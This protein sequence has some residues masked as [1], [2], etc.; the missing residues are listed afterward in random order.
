MVSASQANVAN[1]L[2][3]LE[4]PLNES[5][6][7][8]PLWTQA[9]NITYERFKPYMVGK[10]RGFLSFAQACRAATKE[11]RPGFP[12]S[13]FGHS[14][15]GSIMNK[16]DPQHP[17]YDPQSLFEWFLHYTQPFNGHPQMSVHKFSIKVEMK[18]VK[19]ILEEDAGRAFMGSHLALILAHKMIFGAMDSALRNVSHSAYGFNIFS[20]GV[21][22]MA[23]ARKN[24]KIASD[25]FK[26]WDK[27]FE[28]MPDV[29]E[30]KGAYAEENESF[31]PFHRHLMEYVIYNSCNVFILLPDGTIYI[32]RNHMMP[33]GKDATTVD[34]I[35]CNTIKHEY[36]CLRA[37]PR[38]MP[39]W[40]D[41][42]KFYGDDSHHDITNKSPL[43]EDEAWFNRECERINLF[44]VDHKITTGPVGWTFM[45]F[46]AQYW[47]K[48]STIVV[49]V[50]RGD[51]LRAGFYVYD[52]PSNVTN[53]SMRCLALT[54]LAYA[55][56]SELYEEFKS[57]FIH[58]FQYSKFSEED[59]NF[60]YRCVQH[61]APSRLENLW[62]GREGLESILGSDYSLDWLYRQEE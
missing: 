27:R 32:S 25:D 31:D 49:P 21:H 60:V 19:Q 15:K 36:L 30:I 13:Y 45:G 51:R 4:Q 33:S 2:T 28:A 39:D 6:L 10:G 16:L 12:D 50:F 41:L 57:V 9:R 23:M 17:G 43:F 34:N 37:D 3:I 52:D 62:F 54:A 11:A 1:N 56:S 29:Y 7:D 61:T 26:K 58:W 22:R 42:T 35:I 44:P 59:H 38:Y 47:W 24:T 18:K 48:E 14:T 20:G 40:K 5:H 46:T 8:D 53:I 55:H